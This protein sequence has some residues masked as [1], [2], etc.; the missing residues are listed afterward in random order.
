MDKPPGKGSGE[1]IEP[2]EKRLSLRNLQRRVSN[3]RK[4]LDNSWMDEENPIKLDDYSWNSVEHYVQANKFKQLLQTFMHN[5]LQKMKAI[6][7][8]I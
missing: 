7:Q 5:S 6:Y 4:K 1:K 3:W 8:Q 2:P